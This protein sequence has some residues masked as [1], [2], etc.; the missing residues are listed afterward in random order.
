MDWIRIGIG[1]VFSVD[2]FGFL[3]RYY[4]ILTVPVN[5]I[6]FYTVL[7]I[8]SGSVLD[9]YSGASWIRIHI[10]NADSDSNQEGQM[11]ADPCGQCCGDGAAL[12]SWSRNSEKR[13]GSGS[14][15]SFDPMFKE[16]R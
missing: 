6:L 4:D 1:S 15:S 12:F 10:L 13:G 5:H 11:N 7:W 3:I 8:G 16:E 2:G 14:S 9:P